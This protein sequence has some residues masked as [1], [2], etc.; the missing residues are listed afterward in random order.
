MSQVYSYHDL[1]LQDPN[2]PLWP[3]AMNLNPYPNPPQPMWA[4]EHDACR[5]ADA[6]MNEHD[7]ADQDW[8][9]PGKQHGTNN[10][11]DD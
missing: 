6:A 8:A 1:S 10:K 2:W 11:W 4:V 3:S 5:H 9:N 7:Y